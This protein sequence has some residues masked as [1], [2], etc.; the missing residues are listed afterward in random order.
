MKRII[1]ALLLMISVVLSFVSCGEHVPA[2]NP[3]PTDNPSAG[4]NTTD[5]PEDATPPATDGTQLPFTV[6]IML[7]GKVYVPT[8]TLQ[9]RWSDGRSTFTEPV[10]ADGKASVTGLDGDYTVTLL[11]LPK[12]YTYNP[13]I[14]TATNDRRDVQIEL[15]KIGTALGNGDGLFSSKEITRSGYYRASI[16]KAGQRIY[17]TFRP[18][19]AGV[20]YVESIMDVS[21]NMYN[22]ILTKYSASF[23]YKEDLGDVDDGGASGSY[24][25]N[26]LYKIAISEE[27]LSQVNEYTFAVRVEGKDVVYPVDV[28]FAVTY[29]G[30]AED[31][32]HVDDRI[33]I[34]EEIPSNLNYFDKL[35]F[36]TLREADLTETDKNNPTYK[37]LKEYHA[38]LDENMRIFGNTNWVDAAER[39]DGKKVFNDDGFKLNP[40]D[41]YYHIFNEDKYAA[42]GGWGPIIYAFVSEKCQ[43]LEN[44][45]NLVEYIGNKALTVSD[46]TENYKLFVE[47]FHELTLRHSRESGPY[48][49]NDTCPCY[50][51]Y[52]T[53][54][55]ALL[56]ALDQYTNAVDKGD[57]NVTSYVKAIW[58]CKN[59]L[60]HTNGGSCDSSCTSCN[61][62]CRH[63]PDANRYQMGYADIAI[64]GRAPVTEELME[65]LQKFS[66]NQRYFADGN[67]WV[68]KFGY[69]AFED[70]QWLF[71]CGYYTD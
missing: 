18:T 46:G 8:G 68:E 11:N 44:P 55:D 63:L 7:N 62:S 12:G 53:A 13:N 65:F 16:T 5:T 42:T 1:V 35:I 26:F 49:C 64:D 50:S 45:L 36:S 37:W 31:L 3:P 33:V 17:Y 61:D 6:T 2:E 67:G 60:D 9:V 29:V 34:P 56:D 14:Y 54:K 23:A 19:K 21:A 58:T 52:K 15:V 28:D 57:A 4:G 10:G 43:F 39:V 51:T 40:D 27:E 38:Y 24:T 30:A 47:G 41:G 71:A 48:F 59:N 32:E 69:T 20:Y 22:P 70:S 66:E 25:K